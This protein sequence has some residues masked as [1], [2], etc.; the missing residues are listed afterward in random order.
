MPEWVT[1]IRYR[2][3]DFVVLVAVAVVL[4]RICSLVVLIKTC[5]I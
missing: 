1:G 4:D 2:F 3:P 5:V